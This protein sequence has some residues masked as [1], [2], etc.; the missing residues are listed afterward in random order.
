M[1]TLKTHTHT[2]HTDR[3]THIPQWMQDVCAGVH[4][5]VKSTRILIKQEPVAEKTD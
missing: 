4:I 2:L 5:V 3:Q 1:H